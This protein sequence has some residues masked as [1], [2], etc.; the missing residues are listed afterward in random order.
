M[1]IKIC[2]A[3][4]DEIVKA[5]QIHYVYSVNTVLNKDSGTL[6]VQVLIRE[7]DEK[8]S[9]CGN[10]MRSSFEGNFVSKSLTMGT[11]WVYCGNSMGLSFN[12]GT[13]EVSLET[14]WVQV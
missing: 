9:H 7:L 14:L 8:K 5:E 1:V 6:W 4:K 12:K 2:T 11:L 3:L 10:S 13:L